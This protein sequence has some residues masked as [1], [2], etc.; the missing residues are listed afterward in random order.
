MRFYL[1]KSTIA[2]VTVTCEIRRCAS[3]IISKRQTWEVLPFNSSVPK[4]IK[5]PSHFTG[6]KWFA[7]IDWPTPNL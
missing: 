4:A 1:S 2:N 5:S 6:R 7:V 3:S